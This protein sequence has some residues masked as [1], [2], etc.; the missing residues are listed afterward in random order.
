MDLAK[1][2]HRPGTGSEK[3]ETL[4]QHLIKLERLSWAGRN[5]KITQAF[6]YT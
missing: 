3:V 2:A 6:Q 4:A 5:T 1:H